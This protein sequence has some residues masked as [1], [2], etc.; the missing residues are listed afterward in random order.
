MQAFHRELYETPNI[1]A[2]GW[3]DV[4]S[5]RFRE[6]AN[7]CAALIYP[8]CSEGQ[9]G[10]V[11]QVPGN[12]H[13]IHLVVE[14]HVHGTT[15]GLAGGFPEALPDPGRTAPEGGVEMNVGEVE[16]A[17]GARRYHLGTRVCSVSTD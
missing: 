1:E 6:I 13:G 8:S 3:V 12:D 14:G 5:E 2:I 11:E 7:G 10:S 16:D 17:H 15:K 4:G 9:A